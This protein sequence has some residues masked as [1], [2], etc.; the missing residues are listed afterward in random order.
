M[1]LVE[2][3]VYQALSIGDSACA[4][5]RFHH[6]V[7]DGPRVLAPEDI[8]ATYLGLQTLGAVSFH[9][10][11][12][13]HPKPATNFKEKAMERSYF[14]KI[15]RVNLSDG[16][17]SLD[18]P[19]DT[20]FRRYVGGWNMIA[21]T[22][23]REVPAGADPLGPHNRLVVAN[24][25]L[26]GLPVAGLARNAF[27]AKSPLS[28]GFG[29]GE[30]GGY[31]GAE[32]KRAGFD[33]IVFEGASPS[34]VYLFIKDGVAELRDASH[35]WG[36]PTKD[37]QATIRQELGDKRV[38]CA[39]IGPGGENLVRYACIMSGTFDAVGRCGL[40]AVM[41][42]KNLKAIAV[43]GTQDVPSV[44]PQRIKELAQWYAQGVREGKLSQGLHE[45]G[46]GATVEPYIEIGN[47][48]MNNFRDGVLPGAEQLSAQAI[49]RDIGVGMD[50]CYACAVRCKKR[51]SAETPYR[52][53]PDYGGP[54]YETTG[55]L[56]S[57]C[58]VVDQVT[59]AKASELCNAYSL[60]TIS[61]GVTI[62]FAMECFEKGL[63]TKE[64]TDG[65]ELRFGNGEAML[66]AIEK[67]AQRSV[68]LGEMLAEGSLRLARKLGSNSEDYA[69]QV[70][71]LE[72]PMH[73][74]RW[75]RALAIGY[76]VSPTGADHI[77][78]PHDDGLVAAN[79]DGWIRYG[80][81]RSRG[82]LE[83]MPLEALDAAKARVA[84]YWSH[85]RTLLNCLCMCLFTSWSPDQRVELVRAATGWD[86][87][88]YELVK[89]AERAWTLARVF[90]V[91]EG[92]GAADDRL[93][94]RL[95]GP[96]RDGPLADAGIDRD[97]LQEA[98]HVYYGMLGW[99]AETGV[100]L[101]AKLHELG[102]PW[103]IEHLPE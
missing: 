86:V 67:I 81:L 95:Y 58:G 83:P 79:E 78:S 17:I 26:T 43:R 41:G 34:P 99:D 10:A 49:L 14:N 103:A 16:R 15:V 6:Y 75:K 80:L 50:G 33:G 59:V 91:R 64:D 82:I 71:G 19:G 11:P 102:V 31:F 3:N 73:E 37:T 25:V 90:N 52:V 7:T 4:G 18:Q 100:P 30:V 27:G 22:L 42:S 55:A 40:G 51:V 23:L 96:T 74:P 53:D 39:M 101:P 45:Y 94:E 97:K 5:A 1:P 70:K 2:E 87:T 24:G 88:D 98:V 29:A 69:V 66:A 56:G 8:K 77:H 62:S 63:L 20:Y 35:L 9:P 21:D 61:T 46:T 44:D 28:G 60:D 92:L 76:A 12:D 47:F 65:L 68:G 54:E 85:D 13:S 57:C 32:L 89:V 84:A 48:P 38:H 93:P 36:M 72:V